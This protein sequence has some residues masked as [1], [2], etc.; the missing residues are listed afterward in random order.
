[1]WQYNFAGS[2]VQ[3]L[4]SVWSILTQDEMKHWTDIGYKQQG[5]GWIPLCRLV[6]D[7]HCIALS[8]WLQELFVPAVSSGY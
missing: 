5:M 6:S 3:S 7:L 8:S 2:S 4:D 1:M